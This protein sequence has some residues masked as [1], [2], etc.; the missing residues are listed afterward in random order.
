MNVNIKPLVPRTLRMSDIEI[1]EAFVYRDKLYVRI[2]RQLTVYPHACFVAF[3]L[4][5]HKCVTFF[6]SYTRVKPVNYE[7]TAWEQES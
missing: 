2:D 4:S 1:G 5:C 6:D 3:S 7:I